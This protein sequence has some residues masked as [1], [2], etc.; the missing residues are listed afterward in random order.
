MGSMMFA[1]ESY[2]SYITTATNTHND[3]S[4][5]HQS[6]LD[7]HQAFMYMQPT[8]MRASAPSFFQNTPPHLCSAAQSTTSSTSSSSS[9]SSSSFS[10]S[11][12]S[13]HCFPSSSSGS[14]LTP[15]CKGGGQAPAP[16]ASTSGS[17]EGFSEM[18]WCEQRDLEL[19][20]QI[21][22]LVNAAFKDPALLK[23][24]CIYIYT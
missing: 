20:G 23:K 18:R 15:P 8:P 1:A 19:I 6:P 3:S 2:D 7:P 4:G 17:G 22:L 16:Q 21:Q 12:S 5:Q 13:C 24:V 9:L 10:S 11:S 14:C